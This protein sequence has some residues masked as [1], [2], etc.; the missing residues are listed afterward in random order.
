MTMLNDPDYLK[1]AL[2]ARAKLLAGIRDYFLQQSVMEVETPIA[3]PSANT[4]PTIESF[5]THYQG[6]YAPQGRDWFLHTSPEFAMKR[7]LIAGSGDI[8]QICKVFRNSEA[9]R[10]HN[11]EFTMLE[12]Y[13]L[14]M[15]H[16]DLMQDVAE[17]V[18]S[19]IPQSL[20]VKKL[21]YQEIFQ[22]NLG[23]DPHNS[24]VEDLKG[25]VLD[26]QIPG[27]S[28]LDLDKD[29]WLE[30]LMSQCIEPQLGTDELCFIYDYPASQASLARLSE[31][32]P[33]VAQRFELYWQGVELANGF[34]ELNDAD[35]QRQ[36][37]EQE[38]DVRF[39]QGNWVPMDDAFLNDM[40]KGL[41][42]CAGV[43]LGVDR[44]FMLMQD[45]CHI[46]HVLSFP[47]SQFHD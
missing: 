17:L 27:I 46:D 20:P 26:Q 31:D 24:S 25:V 15:D 18:N 33:P 43:A 6:P 4:D 35:E 1:S 36:R 2:Q 3:Q 9:G 22:C 8:Y 47:V 37:F 21:S 44:L 7:L 13:R 38:S 32:E 23:I 16:H 12:W 40:E 30:I 28:H 5:Q 14:G 29:G 34:Y 19:L 11:P 10:I 39:E 42:D 41:P 45:A